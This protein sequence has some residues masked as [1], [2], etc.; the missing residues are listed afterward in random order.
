MSESRASI[1]LSPHI[2]RSTGKYH[3]EQCRRVGCPDRS[4]EKGVPHGGHSVAQEGTLSPMEGTHVGDN[5]ATLSFNCLP[6]GMIGT[7]VA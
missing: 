1:T 7:V 2:A 5:T 4:E 6:R 3:G